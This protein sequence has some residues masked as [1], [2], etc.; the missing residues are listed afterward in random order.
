MGDY[1][2]PQMDQSMTKTKT[3]RKKPKVVDN[4]IVLDSQI[5]PR[6]IVM[7]VIKTFADQ[8]NRAKDQDNPLMCL[9]VSPELREWL[10][11]YNE[12]NKVTEEVQIDKVKEEWI[13][14][15]QNS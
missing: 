15:L 7:T 5:I 4:S 13:K 1:I 12:L 9:K 11:L 8:F 2:K 3:N 10:K 6:S 14:K